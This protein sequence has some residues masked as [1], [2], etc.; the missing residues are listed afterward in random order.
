MPPFLNLPMIHQ[1]LMHQYRFMIA[2]IEKIFS[3]TLKQQCFYV[4]IQN[5]GFVLIVSFQ[6]PPLQVASEFNCSVR[7]N[8]FTH[9]ANLDCVHCPEDFT[10]NVVIDLCRRCAAIKL[11]GRLLMISLCFF[12]VSQLIVK[13]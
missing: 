3:Q 10:W 11:K 13:P 5:A 12:Q 4:Q 1:E 9:I 7:I 8:F 6:K 2:L